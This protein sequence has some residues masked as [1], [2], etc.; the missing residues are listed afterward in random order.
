[1]RARVHKRTPLAWLLPLGTREEAKPFGRLHALAVVPE[2][3]RRAEEGEAVRTG[4]IEELGHSHRVPL[5]GPLELLLVQW[6]LSKRPLLT[7]WPCG[8]ARARRCVA[9]RRG[10]EACD[11]RDGMQPCYAQSERWRSHPQ[12]EHER[13]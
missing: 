2:D 12:K 9:D 6:T 4:G 5:L 13:R 3:N 7:H 11:T 1:M 10:G 8:H